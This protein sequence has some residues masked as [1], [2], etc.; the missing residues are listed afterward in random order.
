M[1][2][3]P[4]IASNSKRFELILMDM[5]M[6]VMGGIE[7]TESIRAREM[8]RSWVM[9]QEFSPVQIIAMTANAMDGDRDRCLQAGMNDYVAK[10]IKPNEFYA[11]IDRC[12]TPEGDGDS[13]LSLSEAALS[14]TSLDLT[15]AARDLGD[16][17]LLADHSR[18]AGRRMDG[19]HGTNMGQPA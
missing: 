19:A 1:V 11:A 15:A 13:A 17:E 14:A 4:L 18:D 5:Q 8:R 7:A 3:K 9:S 16:R 6:P 10:P 2:R 12:L